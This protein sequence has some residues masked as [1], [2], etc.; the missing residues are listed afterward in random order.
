LAKCLLGRAS[1]LQFVH[2]FFMRPDLIS[3]VPSQPMARAIIK[4]FIPG[5]DLAEKRDVQIGRACNV[6]SF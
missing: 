6:G 4:S 1:I 5:A 3:T 2:R